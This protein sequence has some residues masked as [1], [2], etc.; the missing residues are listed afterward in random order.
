MWGSQRG[1]KSKCTGYLSFHWE[2]RALL[3]CAGRA[4]APLGH[5][6]PGEAVPALERERVYVIIGSYI[7]A[8][9]TPLYLAPL[10]GASWAAAC[11]QCGWGGPEG[12]SA[13]GR[14]GS[15]GLQGS[16]GYL[17]WA[18]AGRTGVS[19]SAGIKPHRLGLSASRCERGRFR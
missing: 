9:S 13:V 1:C 16:S 19:D 2:E 4:G 8:F 5:R 15:Q 14:A 6:V 17:T 7:I 10:P 11:A 18:S 12:G 3:H